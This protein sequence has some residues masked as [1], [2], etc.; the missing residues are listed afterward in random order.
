MKKQYEEL[1]PF[2][3]TNRTLF[4][5]EAEIEEAKRGGIAPRCL[6]HAEA[7]PGFSVP[8]NKCISWSRIILKKETPA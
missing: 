3:S 8:I 2:K 6:T 4:T 7:M 1:H 5:S